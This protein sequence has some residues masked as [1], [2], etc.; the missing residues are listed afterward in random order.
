MLRKALVATAIVLAGCAARFYNLEGTVLCGFDAWAYFDLA[1]RWDFS[2]AMFKAA[3][4]KFGYVTLI[5]HVRQ[6]LPHTDAFLAYLSAGCDTASILLVGA[7]AWRLGFGFA[8]GVGAALVYA[9]TPSVII[10]A[11]ESLPHAPANAVFLASLLAWAMA[12]QIRAGLRR[13]AAFAATGLLVGIACTMHPT[14]LALPAIYWAIICWEAFRGRVGWC[15]LGQAVAGFGLG[16]A[17]PYV[18]FAHKISG[19]LDLLA[20]GRKLLGLYLTHMSFLEPQHR[21]VAHPP[22]IS[23]EK[24]DA[25]LGQAIFRD[26]LGPISGSLLVLALVGAL[27]LRLRKRP[28]PQP[29]EGEALC[30]PSGLVPLTGFALLLLT[31]YVMRIYGPDPLHWGALYFI[32]FLPMS[33]LVTYGYLGELASVVAERRGGKAILVLAALVGLTTYACFMPFY[34]YTTPPFYRNVKEALG[35]LDMKISDQSRLLL[36]PSLYRP[37]SATDY[38]ISSDY[39]AVIPKDL[40]AMPRKEA[41]DVLDRLIAEKRVIAIVVSKNPAIDFYDYTNKHDPRWI[42]QVEEAK[43]L[44]WPEMEFLQGYIRERGL[45]SLYVSDDRPWTQETLAAFPR[46]GISGTAFRIHQIDKMGRQGSFEI[47]GA[48]GKLQSVNPPQ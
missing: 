21:D 10:L 46:L 4:A 40:L 6:F 1:N 30:P 34:L 14:Y 23:L 25:F 45:A 42:A 31:L 3:L 9:L 7:I 33:L 47:Y 44:V 2:E 20:G 27:W 5:A 36:V 18:Y 48:S 29:A 32:P 39:M 8:A 24:L 43:R 26:L 37:Y 38:Y 13:L 19:G 11:R 22:A 12:R 35:S 15:P 41:Y 17:V 16:F 28:R